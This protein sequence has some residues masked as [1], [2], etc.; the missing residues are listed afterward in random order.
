MILIYVRDREVAFPLD[1]FI[2]KPPSLSEVLC[3]SSYF[4]N[5]SNE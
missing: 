3:H 1:D 2:L 5:L 4:V